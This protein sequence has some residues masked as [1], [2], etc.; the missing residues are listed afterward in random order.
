MANCLCEVT[1]VNGPLP[2]LR[3]SH[4]GGAVVEFFGNVRPLEDGWAIDGINYEAHTK[5]AEHQ[6]QTIA[7]EA[8]A[9]FPLLAIALHHRVGYVATGETSLYLGVTSLHRGEAF[10]A[11]QWI[12]D[13]LKKRVPIWKEPVFARAPQ[14]AATA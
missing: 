9:K 7:N 5:M 10:A 12:V 14:A 2:A 13:E 3:G 11:S 1:L 6:L 8:A 4:G